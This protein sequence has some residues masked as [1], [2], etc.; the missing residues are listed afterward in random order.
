M[1]WRDASLL[2]GMFLLL[3]I[4]QLVAAQGGTA[5]AL[6]AAFLNG[7]LLMSGIFLFRLMGYAG[8]VPTVLSF[9][10]SF[11][12][13][14]IIA[15]FSSTYSWAATWP[16]PFLAALFPAGW[17]AR[18]FLLTSQCQICRRR[19]TRNIFVFTCPRCKLQACELC[20][21]HDK[22]RCRLCQQNQVPLFPQDFDWWAGNLGERVRVGKCTLCLT[23]A[24]HTGS[25]LRACLY[26]HH[27]QCQ[28]CWDDHNGQCSRCGWTVPELPQVVREHLEVGQRVNQVSSFEG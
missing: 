3:A 28:L 17:A 6:V 12:A 1:K 23:P 7:I 26:C 18:K 10:A 9:S 15:S 25:P 19:R 14:A 5:A 8:Y 11:V 13:L 4:V 2:A 21:E 20:W 24:D 16:A 22:C 27:A